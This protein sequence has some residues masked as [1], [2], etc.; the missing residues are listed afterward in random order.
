YNPNAPGSGTD[1][2]LRDRLRNRAISDPYEPGST[3]KA[4]LAAAALQEG[5]TNPNEMFDCE[6]GS[7]PFGSAVI[8]DAHP[9]GLLSFAQVIQYSSN[10]G[11]AKVGDRL[12]KDRL[13]RYIRAFGFGSRTGIELPD[14]T[15]GLLRPATS[16]ARID[17]ATHS[18][19]QGVSVTPLQMA[20]A[21]AAL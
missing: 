20:T 12:G 8:H 9:H 6:N 21:F 14:E 7:Y 11:A 19:G 2:G 5:V 16:W 4:I 15:R 17:V 1:K 18:F 3:F 13:Y 10:I